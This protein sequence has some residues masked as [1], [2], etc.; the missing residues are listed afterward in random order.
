MPNFYDSWKE[1]QYECPECLWQG[2][3]AELKQG[4]MT[5]E[6]FD[7]HCPKCGERRTSIF[8]PTFEQSR[9]NWSKVSEADKLVVEMAEERQRQ[10]WLTEIGQLPDI[11]EPVFTLTW[12]CEANGTLDSKLFL[13]LGER[14][15]FQEPGIYEG[16]RRFI[17]IAEILKAKYG[18]ALQDLIP[19]PHSSYMLYGDA[20]RASKAVKD[21]RDQ[22]R[23]AAVLPMEGD[24][25]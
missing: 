10:E 14:V 12:E 19:T 1:A 24:A 18:A 5:G 8:F 23:R 4:D 6:Y 9:A 7:V 16:F 25:Q 21:A 17:E 2:T 15:I 22:I 13:K 11:P 3:G 20:G